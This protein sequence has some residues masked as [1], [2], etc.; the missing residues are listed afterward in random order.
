MRL[1]QFAILLVAA[2]PATSAEIR[3][4]HATIAGT[5]LDTLRQAFT[6]VTGIPTEYGGPHAN[7]ASEMAIVSFPD[8]SYLELMG[9]QKDADPKAVAEHAWSLSLR[10][11]AGPS[12]FAVQV[13]DVPAELARLKAAGISAGSTEHSGRLRPDGIK[14]DWETAGVGPGRRGSLFPFLIR[15]F[16]SREARVYPT[17][18][19]TTRKYSGISR[20]IL[21]VRD[22]EAA[23]AQY[24]KAYD[25]PS[26]RREHSSE[27]G[28]EV[29]WFDGTPIAIAGKARPDSWLARRITLY[30][31][32]P[33]A[34][35]LAGSSK[36]ATGKS[37]ITWLDEKA[38][39]WRLG[40]D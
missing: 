40:V 11:N 27:L 16:T 14:L 29:A 13:P 21:G 17:G 26:P 36:A 10:N 12:A 19:A 24:R 15:D 22:M 34:F 28:A 38:L 8:G 9:I 5:S 6:R 31:E 1:R 39:G 4:D 35:V 23:I 33:V 3:I 25:L 30:G 37:Q 7:H 18:K 2:L 20:V 32:S